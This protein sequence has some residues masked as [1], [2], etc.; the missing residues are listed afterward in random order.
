MPEQ[1]ARRRPVR[2]P[3]ERAGLCTLLG[4]AGPGL[5]GTQWRQRLAGGHEDEWTHGSGFVMMVNNDND[6]HNDE[7]DG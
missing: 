3:P 4:T 5:L 7:E 2:G 1:R 6:I